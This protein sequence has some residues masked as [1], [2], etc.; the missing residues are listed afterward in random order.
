MR[1]RNRFVVAAS[2]GA[3]A[4]AGAAPAWAHAEFQNQ[5]VPA[6]THTELTLNV[7][8]E[9]PASENSRIEITLPDDFDT[10]TCTADE[11]WSCTVDNDKDPEH[12]GLPQVTFTRVHCARESS[13]K[14]SME[15]PAKPDAA[16]GVAQPATAAGFAH[17]LHEAG[18]GGH[19]EGGAGEGG[20]APGQTFRFLVHT[21]AKAGSYH[22][23]V[24]QRYNTGEIVKW[25]GEEGSKTPAPMLKVS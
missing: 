7:P 15:E 5:S 1:A 13:Y 21:P 2:A 3:L 24:V 23:K 20:G 9:R 4:L 8:V 11:G 22:V 19:D 17:V 10:H 6:N 18:G 25:D 12:P 14:C 16:V